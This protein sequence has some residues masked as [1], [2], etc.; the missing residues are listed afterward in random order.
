MFSNAVDAKAF[1]TNYEVVNEFFHRLIT[2]PC[3]RSTRKFIHGHALCGCGK[4]TPHLIRLKLAIDSIDKYTGLE[5][6][7][8]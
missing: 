1:Q 5:T 7:R 6:A 4:C 3:A 8:K 2:L